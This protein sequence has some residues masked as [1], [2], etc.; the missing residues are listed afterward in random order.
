MQLG[1]LDVGSN[2]VRLLVVD[3]RVGAP[4]TAMFSDRQPLRLAEQLTETGDLSEEGI[5]ALVEA[6]RSMKASAHRLFC[7]EPLLAFSTSAVRDAENSEKVLEIVTEKTGVEL[8]VLSGRDEAVV[9]FLAVRRWYGWSAGRL[10]VL[11]IG[12]GSLEVAL[13]GKEHPDLADSLPLGA[14]RITR[15]RFSEDPPTPDELK[16]TAEWLTDQ[17]QGLTRTIRQQ[18][19]HDRAVATSKTFHILAELTWT[20]SGSDELRDRRT[21]SRAAL[22]ELL[23]EIS[24]KSAAELRE[25][26]DKNDERIVGKNRPHQVVAGALVAQATM[27]ALELEE[28]ELCPWALREG[29]IL[30]HLDRSNGVPPTTD[31]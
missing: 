1:V 22:E 12:G 24:R 31:T 8:E 11:D 4:P 19:D 16:S 29:L 23:P 18:A 10:L 14:G 6:V 7:R 9:T 25:Y 20:L 26:R 2:T 30:R 17:L 21:L 5:D 3:A 27:L 28:L 13:G 15:T